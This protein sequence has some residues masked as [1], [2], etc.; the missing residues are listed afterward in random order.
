MKKYLIAFCL[1]LPFSAQAAVEPNYVPDKPP[2]TTPWFATQDAAS[3]QADLD[4]IAGMRPHH[5]GALSMS[6]EYL[7]DPKASD[8]RLMALAK[9]IIHNQ[10]F[11]IAMMDR[12]EELVGK[13]IDGAKEW[14]Q[15]AERGLAQKMRFTRAPMPGPLS[16]D[17]DKVSARDV[18]FAKAMVIHHEGALTMCNDYLANPAA[19]NKYLRLLCVDILTDQKQ[20]IDFMNAAILRYPGNPDNVKIDPSMIHGM[21]GMSHGA[22]HGAHH[23][24]H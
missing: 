5:A 12:V 1:F 20:E 23:G 3:R 13:P 7:A 10:K 22:G 21:E 4:F 2:V 18:Q 24:H 11:E 19:V 14:R 16:P 17:N 8:A 9:G 6:N 15:V